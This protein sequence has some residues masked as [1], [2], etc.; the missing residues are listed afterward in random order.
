VQIALN[1]GIVKVS[2]R[3]AALVPVT[4]L[5]LALASCGGSSDNSQ[6]GGGPKSIPS[7]NQNDINKTPRDQLKNGGTFKYPLGQIPT[8]FNYSELDGTL[9]DNAAVINALMPQT[10]LA[11]GAGGI[12]L[13]KDYLDDATLTSTD[14][15]QV[16]TYKLNAKAKWYEGTPIPAADYI[17]QW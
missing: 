16:V 4:V 2:R 9:A 6:G 7:V 8:N 15:T 12:F 13:D 17:A 14:P 5:S 10:F 1:G 3:W 11:D